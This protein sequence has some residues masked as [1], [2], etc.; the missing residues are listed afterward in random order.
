MEFSPKTPSLNSAAGKLNHH[1]KSNGLQIVR[2]APQQDI[3]TFESRYSVVLP[4]DLRE[5][6]L[7]SNGMPQVAGSECDREGFGFYPL[8]RVK[9]V[10]EEYARLKP[11]GPI[12]PTI[13]HPE[14]YFVFVDYLQW[15]WAYA[16]RLTN[17]PSQS[18]EVIHVG[19]LHPKLI[20]HSFKEFV[21]LYVKDASELYPG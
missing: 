2:G 20:A 4:N 9:N 18:N 17:D 15:C 1:W 13:S 6:F 10:V 5:Y 3:Q 21:D 12:T 8:A 7:N 19:T 16:I 11:G 14:T